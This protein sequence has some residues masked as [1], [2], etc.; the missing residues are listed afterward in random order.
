MPKNVNGVNTATLKIQNR[1]TILAFLKE[2]DSLSVAEVSQM[3]GL[4]ITTCAL[5]FSEMVERGEALA[6]EEKESRGGRPARRFAF[7]PEH[8]LVAALLLVAEK[9]GA[10]LRHFVVD[11]GGG[12]VD[13]GAEM[14]NPLSILEIEALARRLAE[15]YKNLRA[16]AISVPGVVKNGIIDI[17]DIPSLIG[18]QIEERIRTATGLE[19]VVNNDVDFAAAGYFASGGGRGMSSLAYLYY[20]SDKYAGAGIIVN[21]SLHRGRTC[22]AGEVSF[23]PFEETL[24]NGRR[25]RWTAK[26]YKQCAAKMS[27]AVTAVLDPDVIVLSGDRLTPGD[28]DSIRALCLEY[29]PAKHLPEIII[30]TEFEKDSLAGMV[31]MAVNAHMQ[32][33]F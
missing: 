33:I 26:N 7:N 17:C 19:V 4:S 1:R 5:A 20:S 18:V 13:E 10:S 22:F 24:K 16:L 11:A 27:A 28:R 12:I 6:L 21:G 25:I 2:C 14:K 3:T 31:A 29:I 8:V 23:L 30:R 15:K 9:G 32:T